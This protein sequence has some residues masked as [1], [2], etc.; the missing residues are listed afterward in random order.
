MIC[1]G[2]THGFLASKKIIPL[3]LT[4]TLAA[5][6]RDAVPADTQPTPSSEDIAAL[7][8]PTPD[9]V[10]ASSSNTTSP[11]SN[12]MDKT[13]ACQQTT[14]GITADPAIGDAPSATQLWVGNA[15][16]Q[17]SAIDRPAEMRDYNAVA[18]GCGV[19]NDGK[20]YFVVQYGELEGGCSFC[21]WFYLYD[22]N[23]KQLTKAVPPV[24]EDKNLPPAQQQYPNNQ[25]YEAVLKQLGLTHPEMDYLP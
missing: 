7:S 15:T 12:G 16:G 18:L 8:M 10:Q 2:Q 23:G 24:L 21:E 11:E 17:R 9:G 14:F 13:K 25:E 22:G 20:P 6:Q 19:G 4:L 1:I 3:L 5:C